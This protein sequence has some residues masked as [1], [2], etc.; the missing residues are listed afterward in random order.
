MKVNHV[1]NFLSVWRY[2]V[3]GEHVSKEFQP[4]FT[5]LAFALVRGQAFLSQTL[6]YC[7]QV[8]VM[9]FVCLARYQYVVTDVHRTINAL[10]RLSNHVLEDF[11]STRYS[12]VE[13]FVTHV[14]H[15]SAEGCDVSGFRRQLKLIVD[16]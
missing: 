16:G 10:Q 2:A 7:S 6:E 3:L 11:S 4:V 9:L 13:T 12:E 5:L 15:M 14:T 8:L 1:F